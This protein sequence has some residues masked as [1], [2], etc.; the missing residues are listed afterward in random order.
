MLTGRARP[1]KGCY[2]HERLSPENLGDPSR[3][4]E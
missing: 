1:A 3:L 2:L 4:V